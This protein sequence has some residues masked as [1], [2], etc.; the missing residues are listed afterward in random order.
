MRHYVICKYNYKELI[1]GTDKVAY[2]SH[3]F[4]DNIL[5]SETTVLKKKNQ[6]FCFI[7]LVRERGEILENWFNIKSPIKSI[8]DIDKW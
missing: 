5:N 3:I 6:Y 8:L 7:L 4:D 2:I 1:I